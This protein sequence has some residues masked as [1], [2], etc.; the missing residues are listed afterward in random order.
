MRHQARKL[1]GVQASLELFSF[2]HAYEVAWAS[3]I[4][5]ELWAGSEDVYLQFLKEAC[6]DYENQFDAG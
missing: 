3:I 4:P 6:R 1:F 5:D 2:W